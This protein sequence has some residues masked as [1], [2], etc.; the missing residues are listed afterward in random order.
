MPAIIAK[1]LGHK[2]KDIKEKIE[3]G[4]KRRGVII[5]IHRD[6]FDG[7]IVTDFNFNGADINYPKLSEE[8]EGVGTEF[9]GSIRIATEQER[10]LL[11]I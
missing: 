4:L 7:K 3:T 8:K 1:D 10:R 11:R 6:F 9:I 2:P 5:G